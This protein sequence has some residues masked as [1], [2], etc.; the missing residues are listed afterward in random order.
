MNQFFMKG[1]ILN[2]RC[3]R[4]IG[5]HF[6]LVFIRFHFFSCFFLFHRF[7]S[8]FISLLFLFFLFFFHSLFSLALCLI[9]HRLFRVLIKKL[10]LW[11]IRFFLLWWRTMPCLHLILPI[12]EARV[13]HRSCHRVFRRL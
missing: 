11:R 3:R 2:V 8:C 13:S 5:R 9:R 6:F 7:R 1:T 10:K 12:T 4:S